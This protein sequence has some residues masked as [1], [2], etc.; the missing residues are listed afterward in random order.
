ME[1][2]AAAAVMAIDLCSHGIDAEVGSCGA[3]GAN[4]MDVPMAASEADKENFN[5]EREEFTVRSGA[6]RTH[7]DSNQSRRGPCVE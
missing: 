1:L 3:N 5:D 7:F 6:V 4:G 2:A